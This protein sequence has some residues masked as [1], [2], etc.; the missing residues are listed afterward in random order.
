M[1]DLQKI[2]DDL[3]KLTVREAADL[4]TLLNKKWE[5]AGSFQ[6]VGRIIGKRACGP[7]AAVHAREVFREGARI[8]GKGDRQGTI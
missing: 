6:A 4:A 5:T 1:A 7:S 2:V 8:E 3:S